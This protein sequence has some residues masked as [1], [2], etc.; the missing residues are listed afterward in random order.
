MTILQ[1]SEVKTEPAPGDGIETVDI[2][3]TCLA[4]LERLDVGDGKKLF[5]EVEED[6][7]NAGRMVLT[8]FAGEDDERK[9]LGDTILQAFA[10]E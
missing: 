6:L 7:E 9:S 4:F 10:S 8:A 1:T 5:R 3:K 2:A